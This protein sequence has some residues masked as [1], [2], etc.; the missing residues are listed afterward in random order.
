[1][2]VPR[3]Q[4]FEALAAGL[5]VVGRLPGVDS[6]VDSEVILLTKSPSALIALMRLL[7]SMRPLVQDP[8]G[9]IAEHFAA[10]AA[11]AFHLMV[12]L[13]F[14]SLGSLLE[15]L[16]AHG[17]RLQLQ[18]DV[19]GVEMLDQG[20]GDGGLLSDGYRLLAQFAQGFQIVIRKGFKMFPQI[21]SPLCSALDT[22]LDLTGLR[23]N[24]WL[25]L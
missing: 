1:M 14:P 15:R 18:L 2:V 23:I 11:A 24:D 20:L 8:G 21:F 25:L 16:P 10:E 7:A 6:H 9:V 13:V 5:A 19:V 4:V 3:A 17:A 12:L 22:L